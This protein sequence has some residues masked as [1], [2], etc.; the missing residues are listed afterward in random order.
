MASVTDTPITT[1]PEPPKYISKL[2]LNDEIYHVKDLESREGINELNKQINNIGDTL[3][4]AQ[5]IIDEIL[6]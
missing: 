4:E 2:K 1:T 5:Q 3:I 6:G